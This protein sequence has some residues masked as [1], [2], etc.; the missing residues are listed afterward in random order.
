MATPLFAV[1]AHAQLAASASV[2]SDFRYRGASIG[3]DQPALTLNLSYDAPV[4]GGVG[5]Y[6]GGAATVG[7]LADAGLQVFSHTEYIGV[8]GRA[9]RDS[10]WDVGASN[11]FLSFYDG[12]VRQDFNPE[13]YAGLRTKFLSYYIRYSPHYFLDR[14]GALYAEVDASVRPA[15]HWRL[16]AHVGALTPFAGGVPYYPRREQYD[17]SIGVA[18][19]F[20][21]VELG[22]AWTFQRPG[23][24]SPSPGDTKPDALVV[25]ATC[26]F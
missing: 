19:L 24:G 11:T 20:K 5:G 1:A 18:T 22:V 25:T 10:S 3:T 7:R 21:G 14:V 12:N 26:F 8:A 4:G 15:E 9:G 23:Y 17:A 16:F 13:L 6:A 2:T